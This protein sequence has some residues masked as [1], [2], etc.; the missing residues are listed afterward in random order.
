MTASWPQRALAAGILCATLIAGVCRGDNVVLVAS[1]FPKEILSAYKQA[2]DA[3]SP[4]TRVEFL[5]FPA[6]QILAFVRGRPPG[7]RPDVFWGSSPEAFRALQREN[8]L[9]PSPET[10]NPDIPTHIGRVRINAADGTTLGQALS[11]YGIMWNTRYLAARGLTP[12]AS[13]DELAEAR[14]FGH[15]VMAPPSRSSTTHLIVESILQGK[16]WDAGWSLIMRLA[17]NAATLTER[18]FDV[19]N[20]IT[21]GR[22]GL[23]P[24]VDFLALS[25]K[26]SGFP[27]DFRYPWPNVVTPAGI[28]RLR[29][30]RNPEG[31]RA[32]VAFALSEAGQ[33]LLLRPEISRLP[34]LP[35]AYA[36]ADRPS[37][38]PDLS[39]VARSSLPD[40]AAELSAARYR[41]V[42]ALFDQLITFQ[43][44]DLV[45][46]TARMHALEARLAR[47]PN[48]AAAALLDEARQLAYRTPV[49]AAEARADASHVDEDVRMAARE[50]DWSRQ[51][52]RDLADVDAR[53]D[54][55]FAQVAP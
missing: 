7:A 23:G 31:G 43:H 13:W 47:T 35:A 54:R 45:R 2:F 33:R 27:V 40:Y 55:A 44:R 41:S 30:A 52:R 11:G 10:A 17:G 46:I 32:F 4:D 15:V 39:D 14:Y 16:G 6:T 9:E 19:P 25:G 38:F 18:T 50:A 22:F 36:S 42:N 28:A 49:T 8:L 20:A 51:R 53:L 29:G 48:A 34:V 21:R 1:P 24:V 26:Y 12:P 3:Q 37:G 5:N